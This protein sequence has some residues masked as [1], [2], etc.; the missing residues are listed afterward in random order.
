MAASLRQWLDEDAPPADFYELLGEA[1]FEPDRDRLTKSIRSLM[2]Q[3]MELQN[4]SNAATARRAIQLQGE[5]GK[6]ERLVVHPSELRDYHVRMLEDVRAAYQGL[7]D[8]AASWSKHRLGGWLEKEQRIH[9]AW[10]AAVADALVSPTGDTAVQRLGDT[11]RTASEPKEEPKGK[12]EDKPREEPNKWRRADAGLATQPAGESSV[13]GRGDSAVRRGGGSAPRLGD[14]AR[15]RSRQLA[16]DSAVRTHGPGDSA[17]RLPVAKPL[18]ERAKKPPPLRSRP[19]VVG[20][21][22]GADS[23]RPAPS[24]AGEGQPGDAELLPERRSL[25]VALITTLAAGFGGILLVAGLVLLLLTR[26]SENNESGQGPFPADETADVEPQPPQ[27]PDQKPGAPPVGVRVTWT[28]TLQVIEGVRGTPVEIH[29]VIRRAGVQGPHAMCECFAQDE[30]FAADLRD[31]VTLTQL[32]EQAVPFDGVRVPDAVRLT[33]VVA[34]GDELKYAI[35]TTT[36]PLRVRVESVE[37]VQDPASRAVVGGRRRDPSSFRQ[38]NAKDV[39]LIEMLRLA[40]SKGERVEFRGKYLGQDE[41]QGVTMT[42]IGASAG[43]RKIAVRSAERLLSGL[44]LG[45]EVDVQGIGTGDYMTPDWHPIVVAHSAR[46]AGSEEPVAMTPPE[47]A[48]PRDVNVRASGSILIAVSPSGLVAIQAGREWQRLHWG[49]MT[50]SKV[51][52][53]TMDRDGNCWLAGKGGLCRVSERDFQIFNRSHGL[54]A[55]DLSHVFHDCH[56]RTWVSSWGDGI[57]VLEGGR[58]QKYDSSDG[59]CYDNCNGLAEDAAG[60][61][62]IATDRGASIFDN[63]SFETFEATRYR[64]INVKSIAGDRDGRVFLGTI[65]GLIVVHPDQRLDVVTEREGLPQRTPQATYVDRKD[66]VW[67]GTW[68]GGVAE[69]DRKTWTVRS[70]S[71]YRHAGAVR[72]LCETDDG[73]LWAGSMVGL[74]VRSGYGFA[75]MRMPEGFDGIEALVSVPPSVAARLAALCGWEKVASV[76]DTPPRPMPPPRPPSSGGSTETVRDA[77]PPS[78]NPQIRVDAPLAGRV[79]TIRVNASRDY[80]L[81]QL[82]DPKVSQQWKFT[83]GPRTLELY[84]LDRRSRVDLVLIAYSPEQKVEYLDMEEGIPYSEKNP[85]PATLKLLEM[86]KR[87]T[88]VSDVDLP[89]LRPVQKR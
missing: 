25:P 10:S 58:W 76:G 17:R 24:A 18:E 73:S 59:L 67:V 6:A 54:P 49:T 66:L 3:V 42:L 82:G 4:H 38:A 33:G 9:P 23:L 48:P 52:F 74:F 44:P 87:W 56:G 57:A 16:H 14:S 62:W 47:V 13:F 78:R 31:Y 43:G 7:G 46:Q 83:T 29:F 41:V 61:V 15:G 27:P 77:P 70:S 26:E 81:R 79:V 88:G 30:K 19:P 86:L 21:G 55:A 37:R 22:A 64:D 65:G 39:K 11:I 51:F 69:V 71:V 63:G 12:P 45:A 50:P 72:I 34:A 5:L 84:R 53:G 1:R 85:E 32:Q 80:V 8:D 68:G 36:Q 40:P 89:N 2:R 60:R 28:G 75:T 20:R 35:A